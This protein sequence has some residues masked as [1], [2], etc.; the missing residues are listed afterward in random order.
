M[1]KSKTG[2]KKQESNY[3]YKSLG[4]VR[5]QKTEVRSYRLDLH[6]LLKSRYPEKESQFRH[7]KSE[8][9]SR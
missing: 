9:E 7:K 8:L 4:S 1:L 6:K 5:Y 2:S 3:L